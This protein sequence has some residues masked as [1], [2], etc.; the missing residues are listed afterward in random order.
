MEDYRLHSTTYYIENSEQIE[1]IKRSLAW[2]EQDSKPILDDLC[3]P[4]T[5]LD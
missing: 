1:H 2:K 3:L 5:A 4:P